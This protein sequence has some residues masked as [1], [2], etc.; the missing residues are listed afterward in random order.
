MIKRWLRRGIVILAAGFVALYFGDF[1]VYHLRGAPKAK[2][3]TDRYLSVPLKGNKQEYDYLGSVEVT[4][5]RSLF[6][7]GDLSPCWQVRREANQGL[8]L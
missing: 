7:Q 8:K 1:A 2:V 4:C 3:N 6:P 5:A